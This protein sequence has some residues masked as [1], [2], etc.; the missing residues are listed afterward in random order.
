M[1]SGPEQWLQTRDKWIWAAL[2][3]SF[4]L[5]G[6]PRL[7]DILLWQDEAESAVL[8]RSVLRG[9]IP[10]AWDGL[11][12]VSQQNGRDYA[13]GYVWIWHSWLQ[14]Y[15]IAASFGL[16]GEG[17]VSARLPFLLVGAL[18]LPLLYEYGRKVA[19]RRDTA[20]L[21]CALL[22]LSVPFLL[23][24][25]Q[26]RWYTLPVFFLLLDLTIYERVLR[27]VP[28]SRPL[29][30]AGLT[31]LFHS[32]YPA[33]LCV[34]AAFFVHS[35]VLRG[36]N[37]QAGKDL[38]WLAGWL[39]SVVPWCVFAKIF[40]R[41]DSFQG[42]WQTYTFAKWYLLAVNEGLFALSLLPL[43]VYLRSKTFRLPWTLACSVGLLAAY[44]CLSR[45]SGNPLEMGILFA[46][47]AGALLC[48]ARLYV[49]KIR[50]RREGLDYGSLHG[51]VFLSILL[52]LAWLPRNNY[53]YLLPLSPLACLVL[54]QILTELWKK[55]KAAALVAGCLAV[56]TNGLSWVPL[57]AGE[58][59]SRVLL[60][61]G[62]A[63]SR[64]VPPR[65]SYEMGLNMGFRVPLYDY[66]QELLHDYEGPNEAIVAFFRANARP[67]D[68]ILVNYG[69]LP[70][71]FYT[72]CEVLGG[73][74]GRGWEE[75]DVDWIVVRRY[76]FRKEELLQKA[77]EKEFAPVWLPVRDLLWGN[78]PLPSYHL[79]RSP[80]PPSGREDAPMILGEKERVTSLAS[81][82]R[83]S[84]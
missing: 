82:V 17:E 2:F 11:N 46:V 58:K 56:G 1:S 32:F 4:L 13:E 6:L 29:L 48:I 30:F 65:P 79:F 33:A 28:Y 78:R 19:G 83:R 42:L 49:A 71:V 51:L 18:C 52:P 69:D 53:R 26:C 24:A 54:A 38:L 37:R 74:S 23:H 41:G 14:Y 43:L 7:G 62:G 76:W 50:E 80:K 70:L 9:G 61:R 45:Y 35:A 25:R 16:L 36:W 73:L 15:L 21:A 22:L 12:L 66:L 84:W 55:N 5:L 20:L 64:S 27:R 68:T 39:L 67:G 60:S 59:M 47:L 57:K 40:Q 63:S 34:F 10:R 81:R 3:L 44:V 72:D 75:E 77:K 31:L 8:G